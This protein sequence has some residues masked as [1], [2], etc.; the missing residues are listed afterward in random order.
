MKLGQ[1]LGLIY[2]DRGPQIQAKSFPWAKV[3]VPLDWET[4]SVFVYRAI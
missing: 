4:T 1:H 3:R 2:I